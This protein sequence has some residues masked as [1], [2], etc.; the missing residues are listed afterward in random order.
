[1][2]CLILKS[3]FVNLFEPAAKEKGRLTILGFK[4]LQVFVGKKK[5]FFGEALAG[6]LKWPALPE[7]TGAP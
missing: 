6:H 5:W 3:S 1:M 7:I 4:C 2:N